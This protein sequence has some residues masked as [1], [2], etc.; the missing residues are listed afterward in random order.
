MSIGSSFE[1]MKIH[2]SSLPLLV[3]LVPSFLTPAR[4]ETAS[5]LLDAAPAP[6]DLPCF[7]EEANDA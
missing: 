6:W 2:T 7:D 4:D 3:P 5:L 1:C